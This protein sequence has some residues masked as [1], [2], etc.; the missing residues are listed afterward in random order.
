MYQK[1]A[2][3]N[4]MYQKQALK[5][6]M[7]QKQAKENHMFQ[8]QAKENHMFQKQAIV[9]PICPK[10][11]PSLS[12]ITCWLRGRAEIGDDSTKASLT[13]ITQSLASSLHQPKRNGCRAETRKTEKGS[14]QKRTQH[15]KE[16][17]I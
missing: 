7:F 10:Q 2:I 12:V 11:V 9:T 8:K 15:R 3:E 13:A 5:N 17:R 6:H 4:H 1:Q 16:L 14:A